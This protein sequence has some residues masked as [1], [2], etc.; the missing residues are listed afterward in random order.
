[1]RWQT[2]GPALDELIVIQAQILDSAWKCVKPGGKLVYATCSLFSAENENQI[3]HFLDEHPEFE[4]SP[5][6]ENLELGSPYMQL[7]PAHHGTDGFFTAI[8]RRK[9]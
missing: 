3:A 7:S 4:V 6:D 2:Y 1:M 8:L 5:I 9:D